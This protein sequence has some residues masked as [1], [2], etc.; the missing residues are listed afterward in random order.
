MRVSDLFN[1]LVREH[2]VAPTPRGVQVGAIAGSGATKEPQGT[3]TSGPTSPETTVPI[4]VTPKSLTFPGVGLLTG[5]TW[6]TLK[7]ASPEY[8]SSPF[9]ALVIAL[10][11]GTF[12]TYASVND[13]RTHQTHHDKVVSWGIGLI[14]SLCLWGICLRITPR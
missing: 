9:V 3:V 12:V 5:F 14:N 10:V 13:P 8:F 4:F 1:H 7:Y 2:V 6:S 11:F